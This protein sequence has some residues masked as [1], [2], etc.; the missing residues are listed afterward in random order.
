MERRLLS[1]REEKSTKIIVRALTGFAFSLEIFLI[2]VVGESIYIRLFPIIAVLVISFLAM[3][4]DIARMTLILT[5]ANG[6]IRRLLAGNSF[7]YIEADPLIILPLIPPLVFIFRRLS[8][9]SEISPAWIFLIGGMGLIS[10]PRIP[11]SGVS[12]L[13]GICNTPLLLLSVLLGLNKYQVECAKL[14]KKM[15]MF[16]SAYMILQAVHMPNY[17]YQWCMSRRSEFVQ[18]MSCDFPNTR[19]WGTMESPAA[20]GCFLSV[21]LTVTCIEILRNMGNLFTKVSAVLFFVGLIVT[22][23]R[24]FLIAI[25]FALI[26][27]VYFSGKLTPVKILKLIAGLGL[28]LFATPVIAKLLG[29]SNYWVGRLI[30]GNAGEDI[31]AK[32]RIL[33]TEE[34]I[35]TISPLKLL[36]GDGLG[37]YSRGASS[38]DSGFF[39]IIFEIGLPLTLL[40]YYL[41]RKSLFRDSLKSQEL[42]LSLCIVMLFLIANFSFP[43]ITGSTSPF[44][45]LLISINFSPNALRN[46][47]REVSCHENRYF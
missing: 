1:R 7:H 20:M 34:W 41:A 12:V 30:I 4:E 36:V 14:I 13:W 39:A 29:F 31:S 40:F 42:S 5:F 16:G 10:I 35:K 44:F 23:T 45:W 18:L 24:T 26:I 3:D 46:T 15:A 6:I 27:A 11:A 19:L 9:I 38:I 21:A 25:P 33:Q 2:F 8:R 37:I 47:S 22:G 17:D 43:F 28:L 32:A